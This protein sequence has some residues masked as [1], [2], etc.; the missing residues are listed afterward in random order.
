MKQCIILLTIVFYLNGF[1][2]CYES[3]QIGNLH[4][5]G[6]QTNGTLWA[7]GE[8]TSG[9]LGLGDNVSVST[10]VQIGVETDWNEI[11]VGS[12]F[13][14]AVKEN[15][16][17]WAWGSNE[18]DQLGTGL[19]DSEITSPVQVGSD[20]DW[21]VIAA[22]NKHSVAIKSDGTLWAWGDNFFNQV[23]DG[24]SIGRNTPTLISSDTDWEFLSAG[25]DYTMAIK[26]GGELW[27]WGRGLGGQLGNG[28]T[29]LNTEV[30]TRIGTD[31]DWVEVKTGFGHTVALKSD[32]TVWSWGNNDFGQLG[33][34]ASQQ[35]ELEITQIGQD[36]DWQSLDCGGNSTL[37]LKEDG[38]L[39]GCGQN[40]FGQ[41]GNGSTMNST[42][43]V[44][45]SDLNEW[46][47]ITAGNFNGASV[48]NGQLYTW[49]SNIAGQIGNGTTIEQLVPTL[50]NDCTLNTSENKNN[51]IK[52]FPNPSNGVF[53]IQLYDGVLHS[54]Y[55]TDMLGNIV[56]TVIDRK[57]QIDLS[58]FSRGSYILYIQT[59]ETNW[60]RQVLIKI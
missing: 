28:E 46:T 34:A 22:G 19:L 44:E 57:G 21:H 37:L 33:R 12:G 9:Q 56:K 15:G 1:S 8:N 49:G 29:D 58:N 38:T 43:P 39:W 26:N 41:L 14:L 27:A 18:F 10:P 35:E 51:L 60:S 52:V 32:G 23:G 54:L 31:D 20:G 16:T 45:L 47:S 17:L 4:M 13:N 3:V 5:V 25:T 2:Q 24:T 40:S 53:N 55:V 7:W 59:S 50:I 42:F 30:P 6:L 11:A 36:S 48:F